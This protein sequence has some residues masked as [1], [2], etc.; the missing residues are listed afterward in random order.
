MLKG[1]ADI[2]FTVGFFC[3]CGL[4]ARTYTHARLCTYTGRLFSGQWLDILC[5]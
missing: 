4:T 3:L 5:M 1:N 2:I